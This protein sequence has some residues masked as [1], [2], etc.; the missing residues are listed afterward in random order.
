M[1]DKVINIIRNIHVNRVC[2]ILHR[3]KLSVPLRLE[4]G[5]KKGYFSSPLLLLDIR[6]YNGVSGAKDVFLVRNR[7]M[8]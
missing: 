6:W 5:V 7:T 2:Y 4:R 1:L 8:K 3:G